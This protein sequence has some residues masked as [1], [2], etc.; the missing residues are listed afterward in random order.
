VISREELIAAGLPNAAILPGKLAARFLRRSA[1]PFES[2]LV[3]VFPYYV[4]RE[5]GNL[6]LYARGFDYHAVLSK[7]LIAGAQTLALPGIPY[8]DGSPFDEVGLAAEAGLGGV[9]LNRLL[10]S[11]VFGSFCFIGEWVSTEALS[12]VKGE[13]APGCTHCKRCLEQCPTQTLSGGAMHSCLSAL[14]QAKQLT[15]IELQYVAH[16]PLIWGCDICQLCCPANA[17][18]VPTALLQFRQELVNT[19]AQ[20]QL[21]GLSNRAFAKSFPNRAFTWRGVRPLQ[22]NLY[23]QHLARGVPKG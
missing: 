21:E 20:E 7:T 3:A 8:V 23:A 1:P 15:E 22:R 5:P 4:D 18:L 14:T 10:V 13:L 17:A 12:P 16:A 19:L 9:G 11:R 6:S 2:V